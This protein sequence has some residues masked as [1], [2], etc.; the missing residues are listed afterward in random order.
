MLLECSIVLLGV[1]GIALTANYFE[2]KIRRE[3]A[4]ISIKES[5]DLAQ[6]PVITLQ[7]GDHRLN[8]LLD[9]GSS[10]SHIS[11]SAA[12]LINGTSKDIDF[13]CTTASG[14]D[15]INTLIETVLSYKD[16]EFKVNLFINESL[17]ISFDEVKKDCGVQLHGILGTDFLRDHG[18]ILDFANLVAY[19]K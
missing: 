10:H 15:A 11:K 14:S 2:A 5:M 18:Y 12:S 7:G 1:A 17:D 19:N 9:S 8:F 4:K 3:R 6:V 13:T 16:K